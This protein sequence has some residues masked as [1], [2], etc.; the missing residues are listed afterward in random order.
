MQGKCI[1]FLHHLVID[2]CF[3][4]SVNVELLTYL[5]KCPFLN[6]DNDFDR[7]LIYC[8]F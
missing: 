3:L 8:H 7:F 4:L 6:F 1:S 5:Y 2:L